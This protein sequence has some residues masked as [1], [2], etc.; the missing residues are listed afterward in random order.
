MTQNV[1]D[2]VIE[3][4]ARAS[5]L[6]AEAKAK[7]A[8]VHRQV[9]AEL[10]A[11]GERLDAEAESEIATHTQEVNARR[12]AALAEL[13]R[14]CQAVLDALEIVKAERVGPLA[15]EVTRLMEQRAD[16]D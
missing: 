8:G 4:E 14:Q 7:A 10:G 6:V 12:E 16:G 1:L 5:A 2:G 3:I 15:E 11:L 9:E 13:D